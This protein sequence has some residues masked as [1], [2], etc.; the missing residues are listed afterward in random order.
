MTG[1]TSNTGTLILGNFTDDTIKSILF[2]FILSKSSKSTFITLS[3][4]K[5]I[6]FNLL[7]ISSEVAIPCGHITKIFKDF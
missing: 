3:V 5:I 1:L 7:T 4:S 2:K 6:L